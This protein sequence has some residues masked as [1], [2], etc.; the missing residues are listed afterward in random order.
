MSE[1]PNIEGIRKTYAEDIDLRSRAMHGVTLLGSEDIVEFC[2][3]TLALESR[4]ADKDA[5]I[6][7]LIEQLGKAEAQNA[8]DESLMA[9]W[10]TGEL[11]VGKPIDV[12]FPK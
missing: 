10:K 3:Y 4:C 1:R 12:V 2:D 11:T 7:Q 9:A 5:S 6:A 8:A